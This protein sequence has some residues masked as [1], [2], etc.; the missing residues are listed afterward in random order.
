MGGNR[1]KP[2]ELPTFAKLKW[3]PFVFA[4]V[5]MVVT[6]AAVPGTVG[7][8]LAPVVAIV[9]LVTCSMFQSRMVAVAEAE[10]AA[11]DE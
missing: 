5:M 2:G 3:L 10:K 6:L 7:V 1:R 11:L 4:V 9:A 8:A